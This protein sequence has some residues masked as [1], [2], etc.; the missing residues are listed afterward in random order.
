MVRAF[1][2]VVP[3]EDIKRA[4]ERVIGELKTL[5]ISA[6]FIETENVHITLSFLSDISEEELE[7]VKFKMDSI[8]ES[9]EKFE[10][11]FGDISLIPNKNFV[12]VIALDVKSDVLESVRKELVT[13]IGG[14][15]HPAHLTLARV[16]SVNDRS[17]FIKGLEKMKHAPLKF[18]VEFLSLVSSVLRKLGPIY[19]ELHKS[20]FK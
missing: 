17:G 12:R 11:A 2:A 5:P 15:S 8:S 14:K 6:K 20:Y 16:K 19:T 9:Y 7:K 10:L 1:I 13:R 18:N 3:P 4:L